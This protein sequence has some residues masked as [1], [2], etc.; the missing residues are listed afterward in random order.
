MR[1]QLS[2]EQDAYRETLAGWLADVA[3]PHLVRG[4]L[5]NADQHSFPERFAG[6]GWAGVGLPESVGGQGGGLVE[7]ALTSELLATACVPSAGWLATVLAA[8][9]VGSIEQVG[10]LC[11]ADVVPENGPRLTLDAEGRLHGNVRRVLGAD[12]ASRFIAVTEG[13]QL[14]LVQAD[15]VR[16]VTRNLL[17]RSRSVADVIVN[18]DVS[19]PLEVDASAILREYAVRAAVLL[20]ADSLGAMSKMLEMAVAYSKQRQQFGVP[21]GSFQ[22]VKHAAATILVEVEAARS[23]VYFAA[24]SV[25]GGGPQSDMHAAA[26]KAQVTAAGS[27]VADSALTLHGAIGYTWEHDLQ[28]FYKRA[29]LNESLYGR[30][31]TWNERIASAL[32]LV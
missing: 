23:A 22:A 19:E 29:R 9:A 8:P 18:E 32:T 27:R 6:D 31:A 15:G 30:P 20:A 28:L 25:D 10:L 4:W 3:P 16:I 11:P 5:D 1:W 12:V 17:D 26:V 24:A 2:E 14:R 21:I 7:L 13:P